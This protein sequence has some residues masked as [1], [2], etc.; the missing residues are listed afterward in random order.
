M[1]FL[2]FH[3]K[4]S[5]HCK[6]LL[7]EVPLLSEKAICVDSAECRKV[8]A[9]LP[10]RVERVP[11]LLIVDGV[12]KIIKVVEGYQ[13]IKNWFL[14]TT[15]SMSS[16]QQIPFE[17]EE[18]PDMYEPQDELLPPSEMVESSTPIGEQTRAEEDDVVLK[19]DKVEGV[20]SLAEELQ[21]QRESFLE[22]SE[23][24]RG[25]LV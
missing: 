7:E 16:G 1:D 9:A 18:E 11:T 19:V 23:G 25:G 2:L 5:K 4:L 13:D 12:C 14:L 6:Q 8:I 24:K 3:S 10:Y 17:Q 15:Y 22:A 21:R 20:K